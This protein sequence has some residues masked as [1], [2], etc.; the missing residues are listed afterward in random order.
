MHKACVLD[1]DWMVDYSNF[2]YNDIY[3]I[4][5]DTCRQLTQRSMQNYERV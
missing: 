3:H 5:I 1:R 4:S 2:P